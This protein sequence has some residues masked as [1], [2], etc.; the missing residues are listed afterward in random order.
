MKKKNTQSED[1]E[2]YVRKQLQD[3]HEPANSEA[4]WQQLAKKQA[5]FN[6]TLRWRKQAFWLSAAASLALVVFLTWPQHYLA[7]EARTT[8]ADATTAGMPANSVATA[9]AVP[10]D[11]APAAATAPAALTAEPPV[12]LPA[13]VP[14]NGVPLAHAHF[15]AEEGLHY[16]SKTSG[17]AVDIPANALVYADGSPVQGD[18]EFYYRDYRTIPDLFAANLPMHYTDERGQ[19]IFNTG[20][21]FDVRVGQGGQPVFMA[22]GQTFDV[23]FTPTNRLKDANLYYFDE[24]KQRWDYIVSNIFGGSSMNGRAGQALPRP[25]A[26][27]QV[28][29]DNRQ[30][31]PACTPE[32]AHP[33]LGQDPAKWIADGIAGGK[34]LAR[35]DRP[36]PTWLAKYAKSENLVNGTALEEEGSISIIYKKDGVLRFFPQD[37]SQIFSELAAFKDCHFVC[38]PIPVVDGVG[39]LNTSVIQ[40]GE[41]VLSNGKVWKMIDINGFDGAFCD[42][43][44]TDSDNNGTVVHVQ[45]VQANEAPNRKNF[46]ASAVLE[47]YKQLR[48]KRQKDRVHKIRQM[49]CFMQSARMFQTPEE[50]CMAP[51]DWLLYF[52]AN[53]PVMQARYDSLSQTNLCQDKD[54][55]LAFFNNWNTATRN[56]LLTIAKNVQ[57]SSKNLEVTLKIMGF[58]LYNCDQIFRL[59]GTEYVDAVYR[60]DGGEEIMP[61]TVEIMDRNR[62]LFVPMPNVQKMV[63]CN[64]RLIDVV[65]RDT[66]G[67]VFYLP[68]TEYSTLRLANQKQF[69]FVLHDVTEQVNTPGAWAGL[70]AL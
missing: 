56:T 61:R 2:Q 43:V 17:N 20:G 55:A 36:V 16:Q 47:T 65:V 45:L 42:L 27:Q 49:L 54:Q 1:L 10:D 30:G 12:T 59:G 44:L 14:R 37:K 18:V 63:N 15:R 11:K 24:T 5:P 53:R 46:D 7:P 13:W 8:S 33:E 69:S 50:W 26:E 35:S 40:S 39:E 25:V 22:P 66:R 38:A 70:L 28:V 23:H 32:M 58:G 51:R 29:T 57:R 64:G 6:R 60:S 62:S 67:R 21:M 9:V 19:F 68:A 41:A 48:D 34:A 52:D 3:Y 31:L 4:L